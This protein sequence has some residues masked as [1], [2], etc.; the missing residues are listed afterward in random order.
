MEKNTITVN[1][2]EYELKYTI[3]SWKRLKE[4]HDI[5]PGNFQEKINEDFAN[6]I[7]GIIFYGLS[8]KVRSEV[9]VEEIDAS[10]GFEIMD[11]VTAA[12]IKS[13]P[14]GAASVTEDVKKK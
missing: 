13:M 11:V 3:E 4:K 5:N 1:G 8:P 2:K 12:L 14:T 10:F 7:S 6:V 9:T